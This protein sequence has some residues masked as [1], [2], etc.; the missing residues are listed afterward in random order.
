[1]SGHSHA[2][3]VKSTKDAADAKR[4]KEFSKLAKEITIAAK[5]GGGDPATNPRLRS[6]ME[7]AR[8][9]NMPRD[10]VERAIKRGT[11]EGDE[12]QL[13]EIL[14]EAYGPGNIAILIQGI[15]DNK[16]RT[17]GEIKQ[18]L[19][20]HQGKL[21]DGGAVRWMF[22]Q[23]GVI[24]IKG[25]KENLELAAIEAGAQDMY[26][27]D[28]EF[29]D[30]YTKTEDLEKVKEALSQNTEI[31][32]FLLGWVAKEHVQASE[33]DIAA[34]QKLF[35]VLEENDAIQGVYSNI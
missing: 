17:L 12:V 9:F 24:T 33:S 20:Q 25:N 13:Q 2:K 35:E 21:V 11:G 18:I 15:T 6:V 34:A 19:L 7:K 23:K 29:L 16:N 10:N 5:E 28:N 27:H 1:M 8:S 4:S 14:F 32:S 26:W 31:E 30:V 3:T 22:E